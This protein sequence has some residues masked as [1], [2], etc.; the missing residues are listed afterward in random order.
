[1]EQTQNRPVEQFNRLVHRYRYALAG[2]GTLALILFGL[3]VDQLGIVTTVTTIF[4][5]VILAQAWNILGGYGGYLNLGMAAFYGI[6]AYGSAV[7]ATSWG[8][9]FYVAVLLGGAVSLLFGLLIG[10]PTLRLQGPYFTI[11]TLI[12]G[13]LVQVLALNADITRGAMGLFIETPPFTPRVNEQVFYFVYLALM[14]ASIVLVYFIENSKFGFALVAI[15]EDEE[16]AAVLGV[17][18]ALVKMAALL[19]G[20]FMAGIVGGIFSFRI[21]YIEPFGLF[22]LTL[23]IN[24][25]LMTVVGGSGTWL[26]PLIGVPLISLIAEFL[27]IGITRFD[28]FGSGVPTEFNRVIFGVILVLVAMY[29]QSG[30]VGLFKRVRKRQFTV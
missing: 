29:A 3:F 2:A 28:L 17:R 23:S 16:A 10:I 15:R 11:L 21:G 18:T 25:V 7:A 20:A 30:I 8:L 6:G 26:G 12:I 24:V 5:F 13:F 19:I 22:S 14:L 1:M 4:L 27:R 9:P